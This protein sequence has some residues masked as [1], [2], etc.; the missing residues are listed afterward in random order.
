[1]YTTRTQ[2]ERGAEIWLRGRCRCTRGAPYV[3]KSQREGRES[4]GRYLLTVEQYTERR[5]GEGV[6]G[7]TCVLMRR[8]TTENKRWS[9]G[10][11]TR[12]A[13][14]PMYYRYL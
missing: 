5:E 9:P 7:T 2:A 3:Q 4:G 13:V 10:D 11:P 8:P 1:M 14:K 6:L 12:R